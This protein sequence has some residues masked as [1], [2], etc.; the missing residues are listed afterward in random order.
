[1]MAEIPALSRF[2][3]YL[4]QPLKKPFG[5]GKKEL[6]FDLECLQ[7]SGEMM[8]KFYDQKTTAAQSIMLRNFLGILAQKVMDVRHELFLSRDGV[9]I[10]NR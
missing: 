4:P 10:Y 7:C 8:V 1:M 9:D 2:M 3:E 6:E 5:P